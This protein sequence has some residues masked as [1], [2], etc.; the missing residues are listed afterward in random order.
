[1][2]MSTTN[3]RAR[4]VGLALLSIATALAT[5]TALAVER[6]RGP[7]HGDIHAFHEHD[8]GIWRGGHWVHGPH[9]GRMG[10]WWVAGG[11][12]YFYPAPVYPYPSPW[13]PPAVELVSPP[14]NPAPPPT[15]FWYYCAA[16]KSYYPYV[17]TCPAGWKQVPASPAATA[18]RPPN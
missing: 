17:A 18:E 3:R 14:P 1:M 10:W 16:S 11:A 7:W 8:W 2:K 4:H 5:A 12:W 9:D 13:E 6:Y 15:Q